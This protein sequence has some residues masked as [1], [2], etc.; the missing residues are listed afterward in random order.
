MNIDYFLNR[1]NRFFFNMD[2]YCDLR[3]VGSDVLR[4]IWFDDCLMRISY[5]IKLHDILLVL[6]YMSF[7]INISNTSRTRSFKNIKYQTSLLHKILRK[8][9]ALYIFTIYLLTIRINVIS[10]LFLWSLKDFSPNIQS[11]FIVSVIRLHGHLARVSCFK[12]TV[13]SLYK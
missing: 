4:I 11:G 7:G 2:S 3:E 12:T 5:V 13:A 9:H 1:I 10:C 8:Y 6:S